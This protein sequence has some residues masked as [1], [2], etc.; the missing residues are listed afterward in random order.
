MKFAVFSSGAKRLSDAEKLSGFPNNTG[1]EG[2][3]GVGVS[4]SAVLKVKKSPARYFKLAA[5]VEPRCRLSLENVSID[6]D[7]V[8]C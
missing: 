6:S 1:G 8:W 2:G 5:L 4:L 3:G 7:Q